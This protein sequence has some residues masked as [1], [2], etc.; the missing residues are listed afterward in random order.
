MFIRRV[1]QIC[2]RGR[3]LSGR[4]WSHSLQDSLGPSSPTIDSVIG[5]A[6]AHNRVVP[7]RRGRARPLLSPRSAAAATAVALWMPRK[8]PMREV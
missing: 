1:P 4:C 7:G 6:P 8:K 2:G 5:E 3:T